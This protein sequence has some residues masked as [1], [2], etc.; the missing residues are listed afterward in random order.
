MK[1]YTRNMF[2]DPDIGDTIMTDDG[3]LRVFRVEH[4][5]G[6]ESTVH[7]RV[8]DSAGREYKRTMKLHTWRDYKGDCVVMVD[9]GKREG[10]VAG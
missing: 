5:G 2:Q 9:G 8:T 7:V 1:A 6:C 10:F 4:R 3:V